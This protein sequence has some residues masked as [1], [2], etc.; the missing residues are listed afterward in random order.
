MSKYGIQNG[1]LSNIITIGRLNKSQDQFLDMENH[2][3]PAIHA[4]AEHVFNVYNGDYSSEI[5]DYEI[6]MSVKRK[7]E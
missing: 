5:G 2:T 3:V 1:F 6:S 7:V 4:V